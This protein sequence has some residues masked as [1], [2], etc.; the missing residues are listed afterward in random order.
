MHIRR[1]TLTPSPTL[2]NPNPTNRIK[3]LKRTAVL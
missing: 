1:P 3:A 2:I